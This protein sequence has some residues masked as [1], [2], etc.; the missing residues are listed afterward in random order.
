MTK[1]VPKRQFSGLFFD[2][3][4]FVGIEEPYLNEGQETNDAEHAHFK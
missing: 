2:K 4:F 1:E 3:K